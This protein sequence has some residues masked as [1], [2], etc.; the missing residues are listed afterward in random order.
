[1]IQV[2]DTTTFT[3]QDVQNAV[4]SH[5]AYQVFDGISISTIGNDFESIKSFAES[6]YFNPTYNNNTYAPR[7][8]L[9][10]FRGYGNEELPVVLTKYSSGMGSTYVTFYGELV[11]NGVS[12]VTELGFVYS[13]LTSKPTKD[14]SNY[15]PWTPPYWGWLG[16]YNSTIG[17]L[18]GG[19]TYYIRAYAISAVG[20]SY[21]LSQAVTIGYYLPVVSNFSV[22]NN[23]SNNTHKLTAEVTSQGN[24]SVT[25]RGFVRST[26]ANPVIGGAGVT[27]TIVGSGTGIFYTNVSLPMGSTYYIRAYATNSGGTTYTDQII[28]NLT[29]VVVETSRPPV[30]GNMDQL[31][32]NSMSPSEA[33]PAWGVNIISLGTYPIPIGTSMGIIYNSSTTPTIEN[34]HFILFTYTNQVGYHVI[35]FTHREGLGFLSG[36]YRFFIQATGIPIVYSNVKTV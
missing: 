29:T 35:P 34:S 15:V 20:I 23:T 27:N 18:T 1:M 25:S 24:T 9:L 21:G 3:L 13:N 33:I 36:R 2:P 7:G 12:P 22:I 16:V 26:S 8:S 10:R 11:D 31:L 19:Q 6:T 17:G 30:I 4:A 5:N 14:T 32:L 28:V